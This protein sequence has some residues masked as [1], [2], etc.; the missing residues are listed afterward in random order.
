MKHMKRSALLG[1]G[2]LALLPLAASAHT[3][4]QIGIG[5]PL[6]GYAPPPV[7]YAPPPVVYAPPPVVYGYPDGDWRWHHHH[8][9]DWDEGRW[10]GEREWHHHHHHHGDDD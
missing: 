4:V 1:L 9:E 7:Y 5:I 3:D 8:H 6:E 2:L 10:H